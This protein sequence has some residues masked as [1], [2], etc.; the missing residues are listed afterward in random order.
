[1]EKKNYA[2]IKKCFNFAEKSK[3]P[4]INKFENIN[5]EYSESKEQKK[6][7]KINK[8]KVSFS[9]KLQQVKGY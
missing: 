6:I 4:K 1:M 2:I 3:F 8:I 5:Y 7:K 9:E